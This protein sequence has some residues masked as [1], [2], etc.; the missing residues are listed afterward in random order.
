MTIVYRKNKSFLNL[1]PHFML[2]NSYSFYKKKSIKELNSLTEVWNSIIMSNSVKIL[3]FGLFK[4]IMGKKE[5]KLVVDKSIN[6][7]TFLRELSSKYNSFTKILRFIEDKDEKQPV[8][9]VLNGNVMK[10]PYS[11]Q[12]K[13]GDEIAF[14]PPVGGG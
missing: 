4:D 6:L 5:F 11:F 1:I 10:K 3:F 13:P 9:I 2:Q 7:E 12:I 8:F 14:L